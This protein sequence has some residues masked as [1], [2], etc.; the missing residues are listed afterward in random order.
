[1]ARDIR[2][3]MFRL[4]NEIPISTPTASGL[5]GKTA[6]NTF[7]FFAFTK[8]FSADSL[9]QKSSQAMCNFFLISFIGEKI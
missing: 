3:Q 1:M 2:I 7:G 9:F 5:L 8:S 4:G 6:K